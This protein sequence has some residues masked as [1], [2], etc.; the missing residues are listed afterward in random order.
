MSFHNEAFSIDAGMAVDESSA[1]G[2]SNCARQGIQRSAQG[3]QER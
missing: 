3:T 2:S 1:V